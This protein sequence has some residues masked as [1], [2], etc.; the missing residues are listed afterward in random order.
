MNEEL[1]YTWVFIIAEP[2]EETMRYFDEDFSLTVHAGNLKNAKAKI[3]DLCLPVPFK[4]LKIFSVAEF[5]P[6]TNTIFD[7]GDDAETKEG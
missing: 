1:T 2:S 4:E 5:E 7:L 6:I 3:K